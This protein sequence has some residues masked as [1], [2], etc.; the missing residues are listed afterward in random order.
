MPATSA[1]SQHVDVRLLDARAA[2]RANNFALAWQLLEDADVLSQPLAFA[3]V[4]VHMAMLR[5][6]VRTRDGRKVLGQLVRLIV[7]APGSWSRQYP[8][9]NAG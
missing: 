9:G 4:R 7:A 8:I 3:H 5:L 2:C 1:L 6:G